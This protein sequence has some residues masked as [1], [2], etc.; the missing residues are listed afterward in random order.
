[1]PAHRRAERMAQRPGHAARADRYDQRGLGV[2]P[3]VPLAQ[4]TLLAP[5]GTT[6]LA[7]GVDTTG[8]EPALGLVTFKKLVGGA[9]MQ[10]VNQTVPRALETLGYQREQV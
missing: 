8:I 5:T 9:S 10:F 7:M 1:M 3:S 4:A 6:G 2:A